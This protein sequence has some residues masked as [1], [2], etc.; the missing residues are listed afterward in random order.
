M[1]RSIFTL[2]FLFLVVGCTTTA[3]SKTI[4]SGKTSD[5]YLYGRLA[6]IQGPTSDKET[7]I[8]VLAPRLRNYK[9]LVRD[10]EGKDIAVEHY[11]T[12]T[13][14]IVHY[15]IDKIHVKGLNP[16]STYTLQVANEFRGR[17]SVTDQ[18]TFK[19]LD[20]SKN[21]VR[22]AA[23]SCMADDWKF[24]KVIDPIWARLQK[25]NPDM[26]ILNGDVVYV[27]SFDFVERKKATETDLWLRYIEALT[28]IPYYHWLELKPTLATWDDHDF[29]TNDGDRD[30]KAKD[31]AL[32][33]FK[34]LF[35]GR[36]I[37]GVWEPGPTSV[38]SVYTGFGQRI[39]LMDNR[40]FR[41][42][43]KEQ[44]K[45]E[46]Y[47]HWGEKQHKWLIDSLKKSNVPTW[48]FN[49]N[50]VFNGKALDFKETFEGN[51]SEHFVKF[52][53][54]LK[55]VTA[56]IVFSSGDIHFSEVMRIP[57]DRIGYETYEITSSSMHSYRGDGWENPM[58]IPGAST[59]EYNFLMMDSRAASDKTLDIQVESFGL[60]EKSY[61]KIPLKVSR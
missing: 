15:K 19:S 22:F 47:G 29:G 9:Y 12:V 7:L 2:T 39:Y 40:T 3:T 34:G 28:R 31:G 26:V 16:K 42:P 58:R 27:D 33:L 48:I 18:R 5:E 37:P 13:T 11:E 57:A 52:I 32:K 10:Q 54:D 51:H 14:P 44:K 38:T 53:S 50:Q 24:E 35:G 6:I 8:N 17:T 20:I 59:T 30:F 23:L 45:K 43:N 1:A 21:Q 61:F 56:P 4:S 46:I 36:A 25:E 60:A 49:G 41:Q 55:T